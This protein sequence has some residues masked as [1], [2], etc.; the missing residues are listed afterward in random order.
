MAVVSIGVETYKDES[1]ET[2]GCGPVISWG[3]ITGKHGNL[4]PQLKIAASSSTSS[5]AFGVS[6]S[7]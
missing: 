4:N 6:F 7:F 1:E 2:K 5:S 3:E